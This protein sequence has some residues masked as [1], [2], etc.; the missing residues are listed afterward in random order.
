MRFSTIF[1][2]LFYPYLAHERTAQILDFVS[3]LVALFLIE[4]HRAQNMVR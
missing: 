1:T 3:S 4:R 2:A